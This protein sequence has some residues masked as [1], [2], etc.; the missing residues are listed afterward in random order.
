MHN[1][2]QVEYEQ[3]MQDT[4]GEIRASPPLRYTCFALQR[5]MRLRYVTVFQRTVVEEIKYVP[6]LAPFFTEQ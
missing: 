3:V 2:K 6:S 5:I 1:I 4:H